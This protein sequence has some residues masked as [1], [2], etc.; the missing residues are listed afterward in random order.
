MASQRQLQSPRA[1][2]GRCSGSGG[3]RKESRPLGQAEETGIVGDTVGFQTDKEKHGQKSKQAVGLGT[4]PHYG[5]VC[6][7]CASSDEDLWSYAP[8]NQRLDNSDN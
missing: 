1:A 2:D 4:S 3:L 6:A 7:C 8:S 5:S